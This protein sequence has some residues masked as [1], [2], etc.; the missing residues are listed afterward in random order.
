[1]NLEKQNPLLALAARLQMLL[2]RADKERE[3][4]DVAAWVLIVVMTAG[5]V[6]AIWAIA[7]PA[8]SAMFSKALSGVNGP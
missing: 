7:G 5:I 6:V 8:L 4:G 3:R 1:M 2:F